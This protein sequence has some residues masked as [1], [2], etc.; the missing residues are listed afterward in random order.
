MDNTIIASDPMTLGTKVNGSPGS[1][2]YTDEWGN[3]KVVTMH[4]KYRDIVHRQ[5]VFTVS[6]QAGVGGQAVSVFAA[7]TYTGLYLYNLPGSGVSVS[8]VAIATA[9]AVAEAGISALFFGKTT[10]TTETSQYTPFCNSLGS[11]TAPVGT[12]AGYAAT[13]VAPTVAW[14]LV[15]GALATAFPYKS[16]PEPIE[17]LF[18]LLPGQVGLIMAMSAVTGW[19]G[20][21]FEEIPN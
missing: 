7:T 9:L 3:L 10:M 4:S 6:T 15:G 13:V 12:H 16:G 8:I 14:P 21:A 11:A 1:V 18:E 19:F 5:H 2:F 17:G 20:F